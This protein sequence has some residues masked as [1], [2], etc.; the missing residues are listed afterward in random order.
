M[1]RVPSC[2]W[3]EHNVHR[4]ITYT[5]EEK[6]KHREAAN[7]GIENKKCL[8]SYSTC[9]YWGMPSN[10]GVVMKSISLTQL[11]LVF[12]TCCGGA[13]STS[14]AALCI[15]TG[16]APLKDEMRAGE[17]IQNNSLSLCCLE[18]ARQK[19]SD[20]KLTTSLVSVSCCS[21][22]YW[23]TWWRFT[24][25]LSENKDWNFCKLQSAFRFLVKPL[26]P[27]LEFFFTALSV[28]LFSL[29][30]PTRS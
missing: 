30:L 7:H 6:K 25:V 3:E 21:R 22:M 2:T 16:S 29:P 5:A 23:E 26:T 27:L 17:I 14:G 10:S 19:C 1:I 4:G 18:A 15:A 13:T 9:T 11:F 20:Y 12:L 8:Y 24:L 28:L